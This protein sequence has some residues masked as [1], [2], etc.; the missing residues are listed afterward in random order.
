MALEQ[1]I[2]KLIRLNATEGVR[3][4]SFS[5]PCISIGTRS[6]IRIKNVSKSAEY[7]GQLFI[8]IITPMG[9]GLWVSRR[10][11]SISC[12]VM[13]RF[14]HKQFFF[15]LILLFF[16]FF[17]FSYFI[18]KDNEEACD[19]EVTWQVTWCDVI[20]LEHGRRIWKM[21]SEHL[22]YIWWPWVRYEVG[23]RM[24]HRHKGRVI[25]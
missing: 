3:N 20:G 13:G 2:I 15:F 6:L 7:F 23:I 14:G 18:L 21:I 11:G 25:Y 22:E 17:F 5:S 4:M 12:S 24:E 16:F 10:C 9:F 8:S 1:E 19:K